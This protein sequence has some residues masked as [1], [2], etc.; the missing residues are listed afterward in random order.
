MLAWPWVIASELL[1]WSQ[2]TGKKMILA[3]KSGSR[4]MGRQLQRESGEFQPSISSL[5]RPNT[6]SYSWPKY[7]PDFS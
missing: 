6:N 7:C 1:R 2:V 4:I 5:A 3:D